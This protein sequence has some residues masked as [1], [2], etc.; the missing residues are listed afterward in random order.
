M[1]SETGERRHLL[2]ALPASLILHALIA[3]FLVYKFPAPPQQPQQEQAVNV[4][5]VPAPDQPKPRPAP[6]PPPK[7]P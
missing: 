2:W 5:L 1:K 7:E 4:A 3:A 6:A